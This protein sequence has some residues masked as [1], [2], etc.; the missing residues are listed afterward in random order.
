M[1]EYRSSFEPGMLVTLTSGDHEEY[2]IERVIR[3]RKS[4]T[5]LNAR[6]EYLTLFPAAQ[7]GRNFDTERFVTWLIDVGYA[8]VVECYECNVDDYQRT[9]RLDPPAL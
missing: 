3:V 2:G 6:T 7:R 4:F 1:L 9:P 8:E 5:E